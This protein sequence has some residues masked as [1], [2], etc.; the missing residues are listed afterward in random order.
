MAIPAP[1]PGTTSPFTSFGDGDDFG[2]GWGS[3]GDGTGG[4][5]FGNIPSTMKKRCSKTD[6]LERLAT[7]GGTPQC[8]DAVV[9]ALDWL[10]QRQNQDGGWRVGYSCGATGLALLTYLGHC[11]TPLSEQ[12]GETALKA[13]VFLVNQAATNQGRLAADLNDRMWPYEHAIATCAL[14]EACTFSKQLKINIPGLEDAVRDAGQWLIN[15]QATTG[16]WDSLPAKPGA[17]GG[18]DVLLTC[19]N[20]QAL[21][22]CKHTGLDFKNMSTC[23]SKALGQLK[24]SQATGELT[25][26]A[27]FA[28]AGALAYQQWAMG[29]EKFVLAACEA[30]GKDFKFRWQSPEADLCVLYFN[31][32]AMLNC[33]GEKWTDF[34]ATCLPEI[35]AA[36]TQDGSFKD[37]GS[38]DGNSKPGLF[39]GQFRSDAEIAVHLRTCLAALTLEVYY[40]Y[41]PG[42]GREP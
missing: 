26:A 14:A 34:N 24:A 1:A 7:N 23:V 2:S 8:E 9:K 19:L 29:S 6:R 33:G 17:K 41:L 39:A 12:Y 42:T 16:G 13:I 18:N 31:T 22:A 10:K 40:R 20:L 32:H 15:H 30:I 21:K 37:T 35:L 5:G 28:G 4:G 27:P 3:G 25:V 36:Q 38:G 11:E